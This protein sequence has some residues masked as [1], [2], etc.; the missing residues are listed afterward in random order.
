[1]LEEKLIF[2][3]GQIKKYLFGEVELYLPNEFT[4]E[5]FIEYNPIISLLLKAY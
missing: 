1:M 5:N 3:K 4:E 2:Q